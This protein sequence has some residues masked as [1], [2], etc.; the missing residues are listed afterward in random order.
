MQPL[1]LVASVVRSI[2]GI[3]AI[4]VG[5]DAIL[6]ESVT[7]PARHGSDFRVYGVDTVFVG[8]GW[9]LVGLGLIVQV[10]AARRRLAA[11][12]WLTLGLIVAGGMCWAVV[13]L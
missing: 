6:S 11:E 3:A 9:I 5:V 10:V 8:S 2:L 7:T 12:R 1:G 13:F 4:V